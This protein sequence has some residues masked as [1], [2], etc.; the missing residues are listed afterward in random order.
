MIHMKKAL[1]TLLLIL[2]LLTLVSCAGQV[3]AQSPDETEGE[4]LLVAKEPETSESETE[5]E[6]GEKTEIRYE[7]LEIA[8]GDSYPL[9]LPEGT[10]T[11]SNQ[12]VA[13]MDPHNTLSGLSAGK[14]WLSATL[15]GTLYAIPVTVTEKMALPE[16]E[17]E[18]ESKK[19]KYRILVNKT[20]NYVAIYAWGDEE[21][22]HPLRA[23]ICS[24]GKNSPS[25][26][27]TLGSRKVWNR[28]YGY[29]WGKYATVITGDFLFHSVPFAKKDSSTLL[30]GEY[31]KLGTTASAGCIRMTVE[32]AKWIYDYCKPGSKVIFTTADKPCP[33][34]LDPAIHVK[35]E[36][37]WD[38]TDPDE[39]NPW[40]KKKPVLEATDCLV[41]LGE[42]LDVSTLFHATDTAGN[43]IS[44]RVE[45][46][47]KVDSRT[48]GIYRLEAS[49]TDELGKSATAGIYVRVVAPKN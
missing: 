22:E 26:T 12:A 35:G 27:Y 17:K 34:P 6:M 18:A 20:H 15:D 16:E 25:K 31:N 10:W 19:D 14:T 9:D 32:G 33:L 4:S 44:D 21:L 3:M 5:T 46:T 41:A 29:V 30:V 8:V 49:V 40:H 38:P 42:E 45:V 13:T 47:G 39:S 1:C 24:T 36:S 37:G 43:D 48:P 7:N 2:N 11:T 23:M 28:L